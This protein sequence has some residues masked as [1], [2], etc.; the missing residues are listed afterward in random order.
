MFRRPRV[1][2]LSEGGGTSDDKLILPLML[3]ALPA[4][5][6][7]ETHK[8]GEIREGSPRLYPAAP[9]QRRTPWNED[10]V[11]LMAP[12]DRAL[13]Q[14]LD[15]DRQQPVA[16]AVELP[17][18]LYWPVAEALEENKRRSTSLKLAIGG[19]GVR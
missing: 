5:R 1:H 8:P 16:R 3:Q 2:A 10:T 13:A 4:D 15:R 12:P 18:Q 7:E 14:M 9:S 17:F 6:C 11:P 19:K